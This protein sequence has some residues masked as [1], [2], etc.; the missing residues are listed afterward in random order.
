MRA[1][2]LLSHYN[3]VHAALHSEVT[4][5]LTEISRFLR[6]LQA[7]KQVLQVHQVWEQPVHQPQ[8]KISDDM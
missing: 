3:L 6:I 8:P 5:T 2:M 4:V 1:D 7:R